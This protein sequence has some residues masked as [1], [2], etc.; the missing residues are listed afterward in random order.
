MMRKILL[1]VLVFSV[2]LAGC[3]SPETEGTATPMDEEPAGEDTPAEDDG[4]ETGGEDTPTEE[5]GNETGGNETN[6]SD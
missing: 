1:L 6:E 3:G 2:L 5:E 4:N